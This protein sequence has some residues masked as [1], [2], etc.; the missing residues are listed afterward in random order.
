MIDI[1]ADYTLGDGM[2]PT[3][4]GRLGSFVT[5]WWQHPKNHMDQRLPELVEEL[6]RAGDIFVTL[7]RNPE[8]GISYLRPIPKDR[9][10]TNRNPGQRL[11]DRDCLL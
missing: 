2:T 11:G 4:A 9:I 5:R 7:H 6:A 10:Q 8:D 1:G 3:A